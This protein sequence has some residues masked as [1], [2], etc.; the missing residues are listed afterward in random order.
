MQVSMMQT[1][2]FCPNENTAEI[3]SQSSPAPQVP[4]TLDPKNPTCLD[5]HFCPRPSA[6]VGASVLARSVNPILSSSAMA[7]LR[8]LD[9]T[10]FGADLNDGI[11]E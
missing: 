11:I 7:P 1:G 9:P 10:G 2:S 6:E 4:L 5:V 3:V 8:S